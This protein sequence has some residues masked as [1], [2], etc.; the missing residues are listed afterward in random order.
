[1]GEERTLNVESRQRIK[2][3]S[4]TPSVICRGS[5]VTMCPLPQPELFWAWAW[6]AWPLGRGSNLSIATRKGDRSPNQRPNFAGLVLLIS[7]KFFSKP[8][9]F[10]AEKGG[11]AK[12]N[13]ATW[14]RWF[15]ISE[16]VSFPAKVFAGLIHI[17]PTA[18]INVCYCSRLE[19]I[20]GNRIALGVF[21]KQK[22]MKKFCIKCSALKYI[23]NRWWFFSMK[24]ST[25]P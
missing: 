2:H 18:V 14:F 6:P 9:K 16:T 1:M 19:A 4:L 21:S 22:S 23:L 13:P 17:L 10:F 25:F 20:C 8:A 24:R 5:W 11:C 15:V 12:S 7:A 3:L